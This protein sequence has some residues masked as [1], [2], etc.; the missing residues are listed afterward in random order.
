LFREFLV[1]L[2]DSLNSTI[3]RAW[4]KTKADLHGFASRYDYSPHTSKHEFNFIFSTESF[5][6]IGKY[7]KLSLRGKSK[8]YADS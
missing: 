3:R 1:Y 2:E 4:E 5:N 8:A 7:G 6:L